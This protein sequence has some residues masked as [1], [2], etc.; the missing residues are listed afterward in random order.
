MS[1]NPYRS[2]LAIMHDIMTFTAHEGISG[3]IVSK[4]SRKANLSH[5]TVIDKCEGLIE[6]GLIEMNRDQKN[7]I[8]RLTEKGIEFYEKLVRFHTLVSSLNLRC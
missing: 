3:V 7:R 1:K 8:Y 2:E 6:A 5:Y 4:L